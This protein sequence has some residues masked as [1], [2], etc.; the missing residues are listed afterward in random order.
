MAPLSHHPPACARRPARRACAAGL[1]VVGLVGAAATAAGAAPVSTVMTVQ[2]QNLRQPYSWQDPRYFG[3]DD[4]MNWTVTGQIAPGDSYTYTPPWPISSAS[5]VP[6]ISASLEWS[7]STTLRMTS[8]V[9][10]NGQVSAADPRV[11]H[12][13]QTI[14]AP[15]IDS[16]AAL[17]MFFV[18]PG[19]GSTFNYS[20]TVTNVGSAAA[21][22]V[23]LSGQESNG[24]V[25]NYAPFCNRADAD[26][27]GW[28]DTLEQGTV[29]LTAPAAGTTEQKLGVLGTDY[30][31]GR[32]STSTPND[33]VDSYPPDVNDDGTVTQADV[34]AISAWVGQGTG[35]PF[36]RVDYTGVGPNTYQAQSGLWRRYDL[37]GDGL[38]TAAD[39][40][41]VQAEVGRPVPDP[42]DVIAPWVAFDRSAGTS[43]PRRTSVFLGANA[44]D[45]RA[46][47]AV[48]FAINGSTLTQQCTDPLTEMADPTAI[49]DPTT[50]EYGC[51]WSTPGKRT[52]VTLTVSATDAAGHT[53]TDTVKLTV[54]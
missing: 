9:P 52:T 11:N 37:N 16:S 5:E 4:F 22:S 25:A 50:P 30:L 42:V 19:D 36:A 53:S 18:P 20:I 15:V 39:V 44:R 47:T 54:S 49:H 7:G 28:N 24:Y 17:C 51:A 12:V 33:E 34:D 27:D 48:H 13:G 45:N 6:A 26:G 31:Q 43:F 2:S 41:W 1:A 40:A 23:K 32:G 3:V 35:V 29:D 10:M 46:L 8:A 21:T 14:S 38:V